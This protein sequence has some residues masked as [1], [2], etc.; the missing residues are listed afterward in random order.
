MIVQ[1]SRSSSIVNTIIID[2]HTSN[3]WGDKKY[4]ILYVDDLALLGNLVEEVS[5]KFVVGGEMR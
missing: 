3:G 2:V 1:E 5:K 4:K